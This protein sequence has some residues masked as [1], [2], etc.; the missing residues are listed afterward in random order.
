MIA[1]MPLDDAQSAAA[2]PK[3][4]TPPR[5]S[6]TTSCT[7]P[8]NICAVRGG[9]AWRRRSMIAWSTCAIGR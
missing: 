2:M 9:N 4:S 1:Y 3:V 6:L 8:E 5:R 7:T